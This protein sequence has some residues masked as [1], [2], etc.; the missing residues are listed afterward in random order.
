MTN[1]AVPFFGGIPVE[2]D[3]KRLDEAFGIP[4]EG[5]F[6]SHAQL[7]EIIGSPW[8]S[9]RYRT[10]L[11]VWRRKLLTNHNLDTFIDPGRGMKILT[12]PERTEVS[13]LNFKEHVR[14]VRRS[15]IRAQIIP[16]KG[17]TPEQIRLRDHVQVTLARAYMAVS[18]EVKALKPP[19]SPTA[20]PRR[21]IASG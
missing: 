20:N 7:A 19:S 14:G 3:V 18:S 9:S 4:E 21:Q 10:V 2:P 6:L 12:P 1:R 17:L 5:A 11:H 16:D 13:Q 8:K 15:A